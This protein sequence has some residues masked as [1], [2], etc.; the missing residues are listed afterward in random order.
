MGSDS[1]ANTDQIPAHTHGAEDFVHEVGILVMLTVQ[2]NWV[3]MPVCKNMG[4]DVKRY[5]F[6]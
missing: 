6:T 2:L 1:H 3:V 5:L 4:K